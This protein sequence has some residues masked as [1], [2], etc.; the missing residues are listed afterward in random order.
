MIDEWNTKSKRSKKEE[1]KTGTLNAYDFSVFVGSFGRFFV[2]VYMSTKSHLSRASTYFRESYTQRNTYTKYD[3]FLKWLCAHFF[4]SSFDLPTM[5]FSREWKRFFFST[6]CIQAIKHI[7]WIVCVFSAVFA[8]FFS[9]AKDR[10]YIVIRRY[11]LIF[12][13]IICAYGP[14]FY[15][16]LIQSNNVISWNEREMKRQQQQQQQQRQQ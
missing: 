9:E 8:L 5:R 16:V 6:V 13:V 14:S 10:S 2:V 4:S 12:V 7:L 11:L 1:K 3:Y 15:T